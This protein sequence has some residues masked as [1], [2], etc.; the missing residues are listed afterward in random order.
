MKIARINSVF[1]VALL[2]LLLAPSGLAQSIAI[3][4]GQFQSAD[5]N[6]RMEAFYRIL[7]PVLGER[8]NMGENV[9][10]LLRDHQ[11]ERQIIV[12]ALIDLLRR[13]NIRVLSPFGEKFSN[14]YGDLIWCIATLHDARSADALL[15][16]VKTGNLATDG[17][18]VLGEEAL[19][20]TLP[21]LDSN[22]SGVR[23]GVL[24][25]ME[26]MVN[27]SAQSPLGIAATAQVRVALLRGVGDEDDFNRRVAIRALEPFTDRE[28][29][30]VVLDRST[31]D[32]SPLVRKAAEDWLQKNP[33]Q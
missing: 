10:K 2:A 8:L 9:S 30:K 15:G 1:V 33:S 24:R 6:V 20:V 3:S 5:E 12:P 29:R 11:S 25:V 21:A 22:D 4:L 13:E 19:P 17:L 18:A 28:V 14:Y 16:A 7:G 32:S 23:N 26:K 31:A 27:P